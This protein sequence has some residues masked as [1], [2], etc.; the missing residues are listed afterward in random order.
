MRKLGWFTNLR[1]KA[2]TLLGSKTYVSGSYL[3]MAP[4]MQ[5]KFTDFKSYM[6]A[7]KKISS[8]AKTIDVISKYCTLAGW[9]IYRGGK[10]LEVIPADLEKVIRRP[11]PW[12]T[13][14]EINER[15]VQDLL[16]VGNSFH[17]KYE[18]NA[19]GRKPRELQ[20]MYPQYVVVKKDPVKKID[21]WLYG[22]K[23]TRYE[24]SEI[25]QVTYLP[26][27]LDEYFGLGLVESN[28]ALFNHA[29]DQNE[30]R[31]RLLD[32]GAIPSG[33]LRIMDKVS[34][35]ELDLHQ[36]RFQARYSGRENAGKPIVIGGGAEYQR[37]AMTPAEMQMMDDMI[38]THRE[39]FMLGGIPPFLRNLSADDNP[40]YDNIFQ[41]EISFRQLAIAPMLKKIDRVW[42]E[43]VNKWDE[44]LELRHDDVTDRVSPENVERMVRLGLIS[45]DEGRVLMGQKPTGR[46]AMRQIYVPINLIPI[47]E[48]SGLGDPSLTAAG[49]KPQAE[50]MADLPISKGVLR[51]ESWRMRA[52]GGW[53]S[54]PAKGIW[55]WKELSDR[56]NVARIQRDFLRLERASIRRRMASGVTAYKNF[57][58]GQLSRILKNLEA[59]KSSSMAAK[60]S[61]ADD[62]LKR[63]F[64]DDIE[65]AMV[66]NVGAAFYQALSA[67]AYANVADTLTVDITAESNR[68][69]ASRIDLLRRTA[70][71]I[72]DTQKA[73]LKEILDENIQAGTTPG[74]LAQAIQE[75]MGMFNSARPVMIARNELAAAYRQ[76]NRQ[77]MVDSGI[78][79]HISVVGCE[80]R[81]D[82][83]PT[84][85]GESTCN[86][87]DVPIDDI[88]QLDYH[89][90]HTGAEVPSRF[91]MPEE[92]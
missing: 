35:Q 9:S 56:A 23:Y 13:F 48:L 59:E 78:I 43:F 72:N 40:K 60:A 8:L 52:G 74:T 51:A 91:G 44:S 21:H 12:M 65:D 46:P 2:A 31:D 37:I 11:N 7:L 20:R 89:V 75:G 17:A 27:P 6:D 39:I 57:F 71:R 73:R 15:I 64:R 1:L 80:A 67:T 92:E 66:V 45:P 84:Y 26:N 3:M 81:E 54:R 10:K 38:L 77:A 68:A 30:I 29:I 76:G 19:D 50:A 28:E 22:P 70:P 5:H 49:G 88:D 58:D 14:D 33:I 53:A 36:T 82:N 85:H 61:S 47:E 79:T 4:Y 16:L 32:N 41:Q 42:T 63:L 34:P 87:T 69:L 90:N 83:S 86:I 24:V 25:I 18:A 62:L 55:T